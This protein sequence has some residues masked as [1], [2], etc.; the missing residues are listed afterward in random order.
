MHNMYEVVD[1]DTWDGDI[2]FDCS[3]IDS[4]EKN[5]E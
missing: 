4:L 2:K 3:E 5:L 1:F